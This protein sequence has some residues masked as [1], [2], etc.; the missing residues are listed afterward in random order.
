MVIDIVVISIISIKNAMSA[1]RKFP[2]AWF[3]RRRVSQL[4]QGVKLNK[5]NKLINTSSCFSTT[6]CLFRKTT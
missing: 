6:S 5:I 3:C 1:L 4:L 2:E